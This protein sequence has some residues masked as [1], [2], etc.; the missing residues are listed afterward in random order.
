[1]P[2]Q[3][4]PDQPLPVLP[5]AQPT[6]PSMESQVAVAQ[7]EG[8]NKDDD[9]DSNYTGTSY[10]PSKLS[11]TED[12]TEDRTRLRTATSSNWVTVMLSAGPPGR[13]VRR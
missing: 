1:M 3:P 13:L 9:R 2:D 8:R 6:L 4:R 10:D 11:D 5:P 7:V 12:E